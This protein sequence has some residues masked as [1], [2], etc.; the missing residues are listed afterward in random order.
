MIDTVILILIIVCAI[1]LLTGFIAIFIV[2]K[3]AIRK[4]K[5]LHFLFFPFYSLYFMFYKYDHSK[6]KQIIMI[7]LFGPILALFIAVAMLPL[8][9]NQKDPWWIRHFEA[10]YEKKAINTLKNELYEKMEIERNRI[11]E[12]NQINMKDTSNKLNLDNSQY[13]TKDDPLGGP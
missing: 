10:K 7:S 5:A 13:G 2:F 6:K 8:P 4:K 12:E 9:W 11:K 1:L 3:D